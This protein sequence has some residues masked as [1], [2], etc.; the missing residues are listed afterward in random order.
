MTREGDDTDQVDPSGQPM[1]IDQWW[2]LLD[3]QI[4][5]GLVNN[6]FTPIAPYTL[7][8]IERLGGPSS[9][10]PYWRREG[11]GA[12]SLPREAIQWITASPDRAAMA[13]PHEPDPRAAYFNRTWPR[14]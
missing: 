12:L 13:R 9:D 8:E 3:E 4:R 11:D 7:G 2:P 1:G 14:R 6:I 10:D 5:V